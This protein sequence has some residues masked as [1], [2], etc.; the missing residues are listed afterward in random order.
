MEN[1]HA[2]NGKTRYKWP[3]SVA[4]LVYQGVFLSH[5]LLSHD[6]PS[7]ITIQR[8]KNYRSTSDVMGISP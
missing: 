8:G 2:I 4:M 1:H 7:S 5:F 3:F 6:I